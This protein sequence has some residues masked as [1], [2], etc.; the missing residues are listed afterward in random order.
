MSHVLRFTH[1]K[2][3]MLVIKRL[4][5]TNELGKVRKPVAMV[6]ARIDKLQYIENAPVMNW[7]A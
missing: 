5:M 6:S 4:I 7:S 2:E 3:V 1:A